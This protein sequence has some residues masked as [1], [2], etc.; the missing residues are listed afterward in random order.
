MS[1]NDLDRRFM[2]ALRAE[3]LSDQ[4]MENLLLAPKTLRLF[5]LIVTDMKVFSD[6]A[7]DK[8]KEEAE[9]AGKT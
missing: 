2:A 6:V 1:E 7:K 3:Y 9:K 5:R 8:I 4:E